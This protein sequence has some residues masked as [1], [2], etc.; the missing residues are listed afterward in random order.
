MPY[1]FDR[2]PVPEMIDL[3]A[4]GGYGNSVRENTARALAEANQNY[5]Q[6]QQISAGMQQQANA[7]AAGAAQR[8]AD[9]ATEFAET[10]YR[11]QAAGDL[12]QMQQQAAMDREEQNNRW[13]FQLTER[14]QQLKNAGYQEKFS[15]QQQQERDTTV[16]ALNEL[17]SPKFA[18]LREPDR[19]AFRAKLTAKLM[20]IKGTYE[21]APP[22][23]EEYQRENVAPLMIPQP[24]GSL[25]PSGDGRILIRTPEGWKVELPPGKNAEAD[26]AFNKKK[27]EDDST[28]ERE[29]HQ[30][31]QSLELKKIR[32]GLLS[33]AVKT[34]GQEAAEADTTKGQSGRKVAE[35]YRELLDMAGIEDA[36]I[37]AA[38]STPAAAPPALPP[39]W[40]VKVK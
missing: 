2:T 5:R 6:G 36:A 38:V 40:S 32:A 35:I 11:T 1:Y 28:F 39:G 8:Q 26:F 29:K 33:E 27:H 24:D 22:S 4:A 14:A 30:A 21:Q 37:P 18:Y 7:L 15:A 9:R 3:A 16:Q 13:R 17:D 10:V 19:E 25:A 20:G 31:M 12:A 23:A 34:A